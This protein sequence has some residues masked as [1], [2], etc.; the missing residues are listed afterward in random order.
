MIATT[1]SSAGLIPILAE[2]TRPLQISTVSLACCAVEA[3]AALESL[4]PQ[5]ASEQS[6]K[7]LHAQQLAAPALPDDV[8]DVA[9]ETP[10]KQS[11]HGL[12]IVPPGESKQSEDVL[13]VLVVAGTVTRLNSH[14]VVEAFERL[15]DPRAAVAFGVCTISG[16]PYWDSYAV[17]PGIGE[18]VP[19]DVF[20]PG[21]PPHP[22]DL[23]DAL[24][25]LASPQPHPD[26][27]PGPGSASDN[28]RRSAKFGRERR[29]S[30]GESLVRGEERG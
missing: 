12:H 14:L 30:D 20:V 5:T 16:G 11:N 29:L 8:L 23:I 25:A 19:V 26:P 1:G 7:G 3:A 18:L 21:C 6:N 4:I 9:P 13:H 27:Y 17:L 15:P 2:K 24:R 28:R 22:T 10:S